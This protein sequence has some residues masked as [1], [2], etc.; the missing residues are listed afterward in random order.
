MG[1]GLGWMDR[2][3][4]SHG[5]FEGEFEVEQRQRFVSSTKAL[6]YLGRLA[7]A[8][9]T[10]AR[11]IPEGRGTKKAE[12]EA[13]RALQFL[14]EALTAEMLPE[15]EPDKMLLRVHNAGPTP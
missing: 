1:G 13:A 15:H 2:S 6:E 11:A 5:G 10:M 8:H 4:G 9:A 7:E 12:R 14:F 3:K